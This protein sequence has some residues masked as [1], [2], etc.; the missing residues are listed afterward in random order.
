MLLP[1][2]A[3]PVAPLPTTLTPSRAWPLMTLA[4]PAVVPPMVTPGA[5]PA[6]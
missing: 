4:A 3:T 2:M 1:R 5:L 6:T